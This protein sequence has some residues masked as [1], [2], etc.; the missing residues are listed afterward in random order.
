M[1]AAYGFGAFLEGVK[2]RSNPMVDATLL[3]NPLTAG[4]S[5]C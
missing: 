1:L 5:I 4:L 2:G 3:D